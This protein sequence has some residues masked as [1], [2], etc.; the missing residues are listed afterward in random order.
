MQLLNSATR[1]YSW[2]S[3]TMIP[4]LKGEPA[5]EA[6]IA[7]LWFGAHP[8][9]PSTVDGQ[10]L[11]E[12]IAAAPR[13]QL[14]A[15]VEQTYGQRLPFLLKILA[16]EEPL[17]LQAHPSKAQAEE[18]FARENAAGIALNAANRNYKD[19]N[20]KPELIVALTEFYAMAGFRP[21]ERTLELFKALDCKQLDHYLSMLL[22]DPAAESENLRALFTTWITIPTAKRKELI[23]AIVE[24]GEALIARTAED[25]AEAW[26]ARDMRTVINLNEQYSGDIGVLGAL[27]LNHIVL[28]PG[29]ALYLNAGSLHAYVS[30][31]GVEIMANSDNVLR[32]GLTPKFVDVPEL[33]KVLT[34]ESVAD[35]RV[36]QVDKAGAPNVRGAESWSYP[37]PI[38]EFA[39]DRVEL[40]A[41]DEV[42]LEFD[43]PA[44]ALCTGG[45]VE[46]EDAEG[47]TQTL[48]PGG[49][50]W[51]PAVEGV[52]KARAV[53][54]GAYQLFVARV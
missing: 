25:G 18:G 33:V 9:D 3:R 1:N 24:A 10:R 21:L 54:S 13:E 48:T 15:R 46:L 35:P 43:G 27:L 37:V 47:N 14:G 19:D 38:D 42:E 32:G 36:Q 4:E 30:G 26:M 50:E 12:V 17:S 29:E 53:Q 40:G 8:G 52:V 45:S 44:I 34:Y 6:P 41:N 28:A 39:L 5:A 2:G 49:A 11:D 31:L 51:L 20:H 22:P 23:A 16:A 7:E